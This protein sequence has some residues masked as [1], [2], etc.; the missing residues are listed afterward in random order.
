MTES[1]VYGM[2]RRIVKNEM[3]ETSVMLIKN[4]AI[5]KVYKFPR[6]K[7]EGQTLFFFSLSLATISSYSVKWKRRFTYRYYPS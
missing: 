6:G 1:V 7:R 5:K 3:E 2:R 4:C